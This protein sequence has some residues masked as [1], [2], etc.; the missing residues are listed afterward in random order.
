[1]ENYRENHKEKYS[2]T[3]RKGE[4]LHRAIGINLGNSISVENPL[5]N[6]EIYE[7]SVIESNEIDF[8]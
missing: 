1:M 7:G 2:D 5:F 3:Y 8:E 6:P 4:V